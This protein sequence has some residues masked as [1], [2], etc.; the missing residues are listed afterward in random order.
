M[1]ACK[2]LRMSVLEF[3][4]S[5]F[6][7][8]GLLAGYIAYHV[9]SLDIVFFSIFNC[10]ITHRLFDIDKCSS[11]NHSPLHYCKFPRDLPKSTPMAP[12]TRSN[13]ATK[14]MPSC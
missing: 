3:D 11:L 14:K 8:A 5:V 12:K 7:K 2:G 6:L 4:L 9:C 10:T 1:G 13:Q